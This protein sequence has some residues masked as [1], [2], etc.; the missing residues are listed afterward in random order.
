MADHWLAEGAHAGRSGWG[1]R[2]QP[3]AP[4]E[5]LGWCCALD[6]E[7]PWP[8]TLQAEGGCGSKEELT[9]WCARPEEALLTR[10]PWT[11][12]RLLSAVVGSSG[13]PFGPSIWSKPQIYSPTALYTVLRH[14]IMW[15]LSTYLSG[16][17]KNNL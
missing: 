4:V 6:N 2:V 11:N 3:A 7:Q 16:Y 1:S 9:W 5:D 13:E 10:S 12:T 8:V 15:L 14:T 17:L